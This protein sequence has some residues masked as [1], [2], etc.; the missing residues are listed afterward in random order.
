[1]SVNHLSGN[2]TIF[3]NMRRCQKNTQYLMGK[4]LDHFFAIFA[5]TLIGIHAFIGD[6]HEFFCV[7]GF[8]AEYHAYTSTRADKSFFVHLSMCVFELMLAPFHIIFVTNNCKFI[9]AQPE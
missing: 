4:Y 8:M 2:A 9:A 1:M 3:G 6:A 5:C 7:A